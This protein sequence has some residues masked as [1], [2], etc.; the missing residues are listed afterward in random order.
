MLVNKHARVHALLLRP[1]CWVFE[2]KQAGTWSKH[3]DP[4]LDIGTAEAPAQSA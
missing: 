4:L 2:W 3:G 1:T